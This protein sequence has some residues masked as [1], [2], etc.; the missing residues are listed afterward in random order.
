VQQQL[1]ELIARNAA[2]QAELERL[3]RD[4]KR[5]A[6]PFSKVPNPYMGW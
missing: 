4:A 6:A 1:T 3:T 2:L 5:Q